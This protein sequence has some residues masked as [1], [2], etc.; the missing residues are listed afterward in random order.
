MDAR[1]FDPMRDHYGRL[2]SRVLA[3]CGS[4]LD[5]GCGSGSPLGNLSRPVGRSIG[6]DIHEGDLHESRRLGIH[7]AYAVLDVQR[8]RSAFRPRAF[9][10]VLASDLIE[11]LDK[12]AGLE[13]ISAME[14]LA[15]RRVVVF[16]PNG[17]L[18]QPPDP[19]NPWQEHISGWTVEEF[20][21][22]G[23]R[24]LGVNGWRPLRTMYAEI[25][26]RPLPFWER[27]SVLTQ[28]LT[29]HRPRRAFQLL[30]VKDLAG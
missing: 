3:G 20:H 12:R 7:D 9:D 25:R 19:D 30:A 15:R 23:Y 17:F 10:C 14:E 24:V 13:L 5:V 28:P 8:L 27:L 2:L 11:H 18:E 22:L 26:F 16:T 1:V 6:V 21:R 29:E 4:V